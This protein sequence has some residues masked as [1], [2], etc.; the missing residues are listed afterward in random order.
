MHIDK[1]AIGSL[2]EIQPYP[3]R[4]Y[5]SG[6]QFLNVWRGYLIEKGEKELKILPLGEQE[7]KAFEIL[8]AQGVEPLVAGDE[9]VAWDI[10]VL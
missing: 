5:K 2:V 4:T 7:P 1:V 8:H 10:T 3:E 9:P 6:A